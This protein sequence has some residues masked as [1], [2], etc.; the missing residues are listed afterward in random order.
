M[1][2]YGTIGTGWIT[3]AFIKGAEMVEGL[4]LVAV[5]SREQE[6]GDQFAHEHGAPLVFTDYKKMAECDDIDAVYIASPNALH[7]EQS[8]SLIHI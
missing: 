5:Y 6:K 3:D 8:L 4:E 7:Y 1:V 2:R